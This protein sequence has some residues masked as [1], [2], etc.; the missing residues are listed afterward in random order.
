MAMTGADDYG[1][2]EYVFVAQEHTQVLGGYEGQVPFVQKLV[3]P[4]QGEN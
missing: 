3:R 4:P 2:N 1:L